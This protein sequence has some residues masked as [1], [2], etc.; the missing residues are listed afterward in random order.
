MFFDVRCFVNLDILLTRRLVLF[1]S[2]NVSVL[3]TDMCNGCNKLLLG[4]DCQLCVV[5]EHCAG[6]Y[7]SSCCTILSMPSRDLD[8]GLSYSSKGC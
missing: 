5:N 8:P 7:S 6:F 1:A 3:C 4:R 2:C